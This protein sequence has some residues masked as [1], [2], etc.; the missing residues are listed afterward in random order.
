MICSLL[1][2]REWG[3]AV[4]VANHGRALLALLL[5]AG[6][7]PFGCASTA[8]TADPVYFPS[9]PAI[10]H[11]VHLKSFNSLGDIAPR[12]GSWVEIFRGRSTG[13]YVRTPAGVAYATGHLYVCD[14]G[15]N[16]V[17]DWDLTTGKGVRIGRRGDVVLAKPVAVAVDERGIIYV[18]DTG[19]AEVVSF[20][21]GGQSR[22]RFRRPA[23]GQY[24]P[25]AVTVVAGKLF[26]ADVAAHQIDVF[27]TVDGAHLETIGGVGSE[28]G[29]F[30]FPMGLAGDDDGNLF[31]SDMLNGRVQVLGDDHEFIR[32]VGRPGNRY[33]DLGSPKH[34]GVGPDGVIFVADCSFGHVHLFDRD[35]R[36][37]ML[38]GGS[39]DAPGG[40]P[41]PTGIAVAR[42]LPER[43]AA[44]VPSGFRA[45]YF[46]FVSNT[47]GEKRIGLFAIG[48]PR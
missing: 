25:V 7:L 19:R 11:V 30:Y 18:A 27:S 37:L 36:L 41:L 10:P 16:I 3:D 12:R 46:L 38:F 28:P 34:L 17:H 15:L 9:P 2:F 43:L 31:V 29:R 5:L 23:S 48:L 13:P 21:S 1:G 35:G 6:G 22:L 40:T 47:V 45:D 4:T 39:G 24:Q 14:T 42:D 32:A 8:P 20:D 33:G 44:L 26:V